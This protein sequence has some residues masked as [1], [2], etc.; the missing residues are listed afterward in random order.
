MRKRLIFLAWMP[1]IVY[2]LSNPICAQSPFAHTIIDFNG[3]LGYRPAMQFDQ[4]DD[5][6]IAY[7][8]VDESCVKITRLQGNDYTIQPVADSSST[9]HLDFHINSMN[10]WLLFTGTNVGLY[11]FEKPQWTTWNKIGIDSTV[12]FQDTLA[13]QLTAVIA[14]NDIPHIAYSASDHLLNYA[15]Y[16]PQL[17]EWVVTNLVPSFAIRPDITLDSQQQPV[18]GYVSYGNI[19]IMCKT[20]LGWSTLPAFEGQNFAITID[21]QNQIAVF[22]VAD[23]QI[24]HRYFID[25]V[26]W[27]ESSLL[28]DNADGNISF[29][30][31][32]ASYDSQGQGHIVFFQNGYLKYA[33]SRSHWTTILVEEQADVANNE[34][35]CLALDADNQ[36]YIAYRADT[37]QIGN[38]LKLAAFNL[39]PPDR[40][41]YNID[42]IINLIDYNKFY[43][44][45]HGYQLAELADLNNDGNRNIADI[46]IFSSLW[47][48]QR[49]YIIP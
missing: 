29:V 4:N 8:N 18:V 42:G 32:E 20:G 5:P 37:V 15:T 25:S 12:S 2:V 31:I 6:V 10:D 47:L 22:Y 27:S 33:T 36:P 35:F 30:K 11:A 7:Y 28:I 16:N 24:H 40:C 39:T 9:L 26:G 38:H 48:W 23:N 21:S 13:E 19:Y 46:A 45:Y 14:N 1:A 3:D 49:E 41:D 17:N 34:D 43:D 44:A